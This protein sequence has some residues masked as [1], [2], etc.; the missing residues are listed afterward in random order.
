MT[1]FCG[2]ATDDDVCGD[3]GSN[4]LPAMYLCSACAD[5][6]D[7]QRDEGGRDWKAEAEWATAVHKE[8]TKRL[9]L[10][11]LTIGTIRKTIDM[12]RNRATE[13]N[14]AM[15]QVVEAID[16]LDECW[17]SPNEGTSNE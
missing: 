6:H 10:Y 3:C 5:E 9:D 2:G 17:G 1:H 12:W 4:S 13:T 15:V 8:K 11:I 16:R 14:D 7:R